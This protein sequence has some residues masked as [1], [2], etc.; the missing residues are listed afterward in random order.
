MHA[1]RAIF[2]ILRR[3]WIPNSQTV[4]ELK[5]SSA[6]TMGQDEM[7]DAI[8]LRANSPLPTWPQCSKAPKQDVTTAPAIRNLETDKYVTQATGS[9][10]YFLTLRLKKNLANSNHLFFRK[11]QIFLSI[12]LLRHYFWISICPTRSLWYE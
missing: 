11:L 9:G 2:L 1:K 8:Y 7:R 6:E 4:K 10:F 12:K 5:Q 3:G